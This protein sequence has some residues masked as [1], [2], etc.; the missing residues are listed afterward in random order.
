MM[1]LQGLVAVY[2]KETILHKP[3]ET[4]TASMVTKTSIRGS[5]PKY[6]AHS[7]YCW[8]ANMQII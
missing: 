6:C 7:I 1:C 4:K 8:L 5:M 2:G 3:Q